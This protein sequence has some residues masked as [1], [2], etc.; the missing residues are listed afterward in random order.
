[1]TRRVAESTGVEVRR[2]DIDVTFLDANADGHDA[3]R[4]LR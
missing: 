2:V 1:V 4:V 3:A